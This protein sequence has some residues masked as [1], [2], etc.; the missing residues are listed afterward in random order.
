MGAKGT[1][2][3]H[4]LTPVPTSYFSDTVITYTTKSKKASMCWQP[5]SDS[6]NV[7]DGGGCGPGCLLLTC[8]VA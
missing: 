7:M 6:L 2:A 5:L 8:I 1:L 3:R 4:P